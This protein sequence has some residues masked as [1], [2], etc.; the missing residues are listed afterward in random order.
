MNLDTFL[1]LAVIVIAIALISVVVIQGQTSG[2]L[3]AVFGGSDIYRTRRGIEKT[4][5]QLTFLLACIFM[6]LSLITVIA[7]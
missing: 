1:M 3:G 7:Q 4:L 6:L 5:Y 2:G